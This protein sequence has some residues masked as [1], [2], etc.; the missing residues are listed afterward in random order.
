ME[1]LF[2]EH[3]KNLALAIRKNRNADER[4]AWK[5]RSSASLFTWKEIQ[6]IKKRRFTT[7]LMRKAGLEPARQT[8]T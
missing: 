1:T 8:D 5:R 6:K 7:S 2:S 4:S 3:G